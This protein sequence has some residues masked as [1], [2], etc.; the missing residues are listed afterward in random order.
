M[1]DATLF[2]TQ[3]AGLVAQVRLFGAYAARASLLERGGM[4]ASVMP[5]APA[6]CLTNLSIAVDPTGERYS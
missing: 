1:P 5:A 4:L 2:A 6:S 3:W